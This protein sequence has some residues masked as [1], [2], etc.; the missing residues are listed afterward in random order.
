MQIFVKTLTG[1]TITLEVEGSDTIENVKAKIQDKEG[2]PPDQQR[3]IFAGKQL[4]DGRTLADY[5]IQKESTLHLVLRLRGGSVAMVEMLGDKL[6]SGTSTLDT[7]G[8]LEGKTHVGIYFSAH[9]CPPCRGFTPKLAEWYKDNAAK[10]SMEI[11][12]ASSDRDEDAFDEYFGEM[13]WTA[14]PFCDRGLKNKLSK[15]FKVNGIPAFVIVDAATGEL[16]TSDGRGGVSK[17]PKGEQF[18]WAPRTFSEVMESG[19]GTVMNKDGGTTPFSEL[20]ENCDA[21][22]IYFSAHWCPPCRGFTPDLAKS[23]ETMVGAGKKWEIVFASSDRDQG[24]FDEYYA[25][26]PWKALPHGDARKTELNDMWEVGGIPALVVV[27]AKTGQVITKGGRGMV[28]SDPAGAEFPWHPKPLNELDGGC[29]EYINE[30]PVMVAFDNSAETIAAMKP[31][32]EA[33]VAVDTA[34]SKDQS[35]YFLYC[36]AHDLVERVKSVCKIPEG[37]SHA[38]LNVGEGEVYL[39]QS[40]VSPLSEVVVGAFV[41]EFKAGALVATSF[42]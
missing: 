15:K 4:E 27:D 29:V 25:E 16:V 14:L 28:D 3:L 26:M 19:S 9:W 13:P 1:K 8:V 31:V 37:T 32:A 30:A 17:D 20:R 2:I 33:C 10:L 24:A 34:E 11:V 12:F 35:L 40:N 36:G 41:K 23:Y 5:N 22:G 39:P 21:I 18:P 6:Q 38:I 42:R 7:V